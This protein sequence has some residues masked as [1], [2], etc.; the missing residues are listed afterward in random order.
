[1]NEYS[2]IT[3]YGPFQSCK[4]TVVYERFD[5]SF[6]DTFGQDISAFI[7]QIFEGIP[8]DHLYLLSIDTQP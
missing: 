7:R 1:M 8:I 6:H 3:I 5:L 2:A 4:H